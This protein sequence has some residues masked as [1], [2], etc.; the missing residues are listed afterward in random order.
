[1]VAAE[2][3]RRFVGRASELALFA[4]ALAADHP[5]FAVL[6]VHGIGGIGKSALLRMF[7]D[8]AE[9]ADRSVVLIDGHDVRPNRA[10]FRAAF[11]KSAATEPLVLL[12]D[13]Y[14]LLSTP[15]D[16]LRE[17]LSP[18]FPLT[19]S[20]CS[21]VDVR[22]RRHGATIRAG[23]VCRKRCGWTT[24]RRWMRSPT[25]PASVYRP[26]SGNRW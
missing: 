26:P 19:R 21:P 8:Q 9:R 4:T 18:G 15:D 11:D 10:S 14:E 17:D 13:S 16:W 2:R 3:R 23:K 1:M 6:H 24:W 7:A 20:W 22:R 12:V 25:W 5:A